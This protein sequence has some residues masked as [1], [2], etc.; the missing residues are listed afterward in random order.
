M[1][2]ALQEAG[3]TVQVADAVFGARFNEALV[4]QVVTSYLAG[5][6]SG[7]RAQKTRAEVSGGNSKPWRQK[8]SGRARVGSSRNP[9]WRGGGVTFAAKPTDYSQKV[10]KKMYRGAMRA[11]L[12]ELARLDRL[13]VVD[14]FGV[15]A[16]KTKELAQKLNALGLQD[17]LIVTDSVDDRLALAARNLP[18]VA[19]VAARSV[20]P[21]SLIG[22][23]N[24]LVT[25]PAL[26]ALEE[27]LA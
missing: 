3:G 17:V 11:I 19:V 18:H 7:T 23:E 25:V 9:I 13:Q 12:S 26:R 24:V 27:R 21:V 22:F 15:D 20:D 14:S 1:E 8:G 16:A 5:A 4:H 6:R 10:N 2:L